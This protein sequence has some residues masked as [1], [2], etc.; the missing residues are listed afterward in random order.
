MELFVRTDGLEEFGRR[1]GLMLCP[2]CAAAF[3]EN[4]APCLYAVPSGGALHLAYAAYWSADREDFPDRFAE[5]ARGRRLSHI[6]IR[7]GRSF[8]CG[9]AVPAS[10]RGWFLAVHSCFE[11]RAFAETLLEVCPEIE[12]LPLNRKTL[13]ACGVSLET[14]QTAV[15]AAVLCGAGPG[16]LRPGPHR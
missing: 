2:S 15:A 10:W 3:G 12:G 7:I 16:G 1:R 11:Q 14:L 9:C 4:P 13:D 8:L 6:G 5:L